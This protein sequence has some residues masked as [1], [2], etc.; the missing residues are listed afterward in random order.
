M[1]ITQVIILA[2]S[3]ALAAVITRLVITGA[4]RKRQIMA[5]VLFIALFASF[6]LLITQVGGDPT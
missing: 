5:L 1:D 2:V 3:G 4:T 6:E